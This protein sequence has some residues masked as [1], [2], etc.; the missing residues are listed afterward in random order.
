M[1]D[2]IKSL[3]DNYQLSLNLY[4]SMETVRLITKLLDTLFRRSKT[5][6]AQ[7]SLWVSSTV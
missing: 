3:N 4:F 2:T 1:Y 7:G 6:S 5:Y